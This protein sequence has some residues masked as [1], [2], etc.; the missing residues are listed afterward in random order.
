MEY[1]ATNQS[2]A[3]AIRGLIRDRD[4]FRA[5]AQKLL[6][7]GETRELTPDERKEVDRCV[8]KIADH[9]NRID[10]LEKRADDDDDNE[11]DVPSLKESKSRKRSLSAG[12]PVGMG[13][14]STP[15]SL[16]G[17]GYYYSPSIHTK[18]HRY[19]LGR[20]VRA[21]IEN[22]PVD[23]LEREMSDEVGRRDDRSL[24][25]PGFFMPFNTSGYEER[26][27]PTTTTTAIGGV[28]ETWSQDFLLVLRRQSV[29]EKLGIP[30][31]SNLRGNY[32]VPYETSGASA[33]WVAEG[34]GVS[35]N[36]MSVLSVTGIPRQI[37]T[38]FIITRQMIASSSYDFLDDLLF[39]DMVNSTAEQISL[40]LVQG[41]QT[42]NPTSPEGILYNT[43][44]NVT[45]LGSAPT[46]AWSDVLDMQTQVL[47][48]NP[49]EGSPRKFLIS[50]KGAQVLRSRPRINTGSTLYPSFVLDTYGAEGNKMAGDD[51]VISTSVPD[52]IT[53]SGTSGALS[54][55]IY[56]CFSEAVR[57]LVW[58]SGIELLCD[59][60]SFSYNSEIA[61]YVF[62]NTDFVIPRPS[63]LTMAFFS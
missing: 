31:V 6:K 39:R 20:A 11:D 59:P 60:Y 47:N 48:N 23:G 16:P 5:T 51:T 8:D 9:D 18:E 22:R 52:N 32:V 14:R 35:A 61:L 12:Q 36:A 57:S 38:R 10:K 37:T 42:V 56:G 58:G 24:R 13:R 19:S 27:T 34:S 62:M 25:G 30:V 28:T 21:C 41:Q 2:N 29:L 44:V 1:T 26:D 50:P 43:N 55:G 3:D 7:E 45:A 49:P 54:A 53:A 4:T 17:E 63:L 33:T 15:A 46:M 40:A